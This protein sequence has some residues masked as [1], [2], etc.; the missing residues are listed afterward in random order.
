MITAKNST[1][2]FRKYHLLHLKYESNRLDTYFDWI[3]EKVK[4]EDLAKAGLYFDKRFDQCICVFCQGIIGFWD[5]GDDPFEEHKKHF[6]QC[7]FVRGLPVGNIPLAQSKILELL[8]L[9]QLG[10]TSNPLTQNGL[11][12]YNA[13]AFKDMVTV[14]SRIVTF[15]NWPGGLYIDRM[16]LANAGFFYIGVSDHVRCFSCGNGLYNWTIEHDPWKEHA[17][18]YPGCTFLE[19][20]KG[21]NYINNVLKNEPPLLKTLNMKI[22]F[23]KEEIDLLMELDIPKSVLKM[24]FAKYKVKRVLV[25]KLLT[26]DNFVEEMDLAEAVLAYTVAEKRLKEDVEKMPTPPDS[27]SSDE[28]EETASSTAGENNVPLEGEVQMQ[29]VVGTGRV[30]SD[31]I[32]YD[33]INYEDDASLCK[34]CLVEK[35]EVVIL[36]CQHYACCKLCTMALVECPICRSKIVQLVTPIRS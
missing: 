25:D 31:A 24:G 30:K 29:D 1:K 4:P 15:S 22:N 33:A 35:L 9:K 2:P 8:S 20:I 17:K 11:P 16:K 6:P 12:L 18:W 19:H 10:A 5:S 32:N 14:D 21:R 23:T 34:I 27:Q 3:S 13:P 26:G 36:P 28:D 7:N